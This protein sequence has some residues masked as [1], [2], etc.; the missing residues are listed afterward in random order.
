MK[1]TSKNILSE[2]EKSSININSKPDAYVRQLGS[3]VYFVSNKKL[4]HWSISKE[5]SCYIFNV[6]KVTDAKEF[7]Y[8]NGFTDILNIGDEKL[9]QLVIANFF[10]WSKHFKDAINM[11]SKFEKDQAG[12]RRIQLLV[13]S[14][15][16]EKNIVVEKYN[17]RSV[18][19]QSALKEG[20]EKFIQEYKYNYR[21]RRLVDDAKKRWKTSCWVCGF[22]FFDKYGDFGKDFIEIHHLLPINEGMRQTST[23]DLRPICSNCHRMIHRKKKMLTIQELKEIIEIAKKGDPSH[24]ADL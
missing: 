7:F 23:E 13:P 1:I 24:G 8:D 21:N 20:Q 3:A 15:I 18:V 9:K 10:R 11:V 4:N 6:S 17:N 2:I 5:I 12:P 19:S 14:E 16:I 22:N